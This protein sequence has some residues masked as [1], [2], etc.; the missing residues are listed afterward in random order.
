MKIF[1]VTKD[2]L[3]AGGAEEANNIVQKSI[4]LIGAAK[5]KPLILQAQFGIHTF[6]MRF[7]ID[8]LVIDKEHKV[9]ALKESLAPFRFFVWNPKYSLIIELPAGTIGKTKTS[10]GDTISLKD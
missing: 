5:A 3:I 9:A 10:I 7:P 2:K 6:G 1:N 4:G 8:V